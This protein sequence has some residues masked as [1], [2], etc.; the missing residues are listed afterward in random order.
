MIAELWKEVK[1]ISKVFR[2]TLG[3]LKKLGEPISDPSTWTWDSLISGEEI[4]GN[5][6]GGSSTSAKGGH[7]QT[8]ALPQAGGSC[9][10]SAF[11]IK[12]YRKIKR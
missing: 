5:G 11:L 7:A 6:R 4:E 3:I 2:F 10:L 9:T 12:R 8:S 1:L